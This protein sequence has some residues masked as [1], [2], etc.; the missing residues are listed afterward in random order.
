MSIADNIAYR[1]QAPTVGFSGI[2]GTGEPIAS[3]PTTGTP[4]ETVLTQNT[5]VI[6]N[7]TRAS[8][9]LPIDYATSVFAN[10]NYM[11]LRYPDGNGIDTTAIS[12]TAGASQRID[13][14]TSVTGEF[15]ESKYTYTGANV[16]FRTTAV[17]GTVSHEWNKGLG[18]RASVGPE[19]IGSDGANAFP[20]SLH[21]S[22][23]AGLTYRRRFDSA[24]IQYSYGD[25]GGSG[26]F[27]GAQFNTLSGTFT[28]TLRNK[29]SFSAR[30]GYQQTTGFQAGSGSTRGLYASVTASRRLGK[31]FS[32]MASYNDTEQL[33]TSNLPGNVLNGMLQGVS[34]SIGYAPRGMHLEQ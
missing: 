19:W 13:S 4:S 24:S 23:T 18:A 26:I 11:V 32:L 33:A 29:A 27:Y 21:L 8:F 3:P 15:Q 34:V 20:S 31:L 25:N 14:R 17:I 12:A 16:A 10:G 7:S 5:H 22:V 28:R 6:D 9:S 1:P 30:F 2:P